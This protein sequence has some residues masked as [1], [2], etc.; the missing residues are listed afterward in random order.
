VLA[1]GYADLKEIGEMPPGTLQ[2]VLSKPYTFQQLETV[3]ANI[4]AQ[5]SARVPLSLIDTRS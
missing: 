2:T 1:T 5:L 4:E 3:L